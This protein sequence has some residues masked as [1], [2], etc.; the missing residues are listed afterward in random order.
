VGPWASA[1]GKHSH[2]ACALPGI[3]VS[4]FQIE[5][6]IASN[7]FCVNGTG[8]VVPDPCA[9]I[10]NQFRTFLHH[11]EV[12]HKYI[13]ELSSFF[14]EHADQSFGFDVLFGTTALD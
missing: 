2:A 10:L 4:S 12:M 13:L 6:Q 1:R 5:V 7:E 11:F 8:R 9:E 14:F 3:A